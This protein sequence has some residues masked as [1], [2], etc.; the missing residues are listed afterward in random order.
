MTR[1]E[2]NKVSVPALPSEVAELLSDLNNLKKIMPLDRIS[3][4]ISDDKSCSFKIQNLA[5][6][7]LN[8]KSTSDTL[9]EMESSS[10][11]PFPFNLSVH[12]TP[13]D[14]SVDAQLIF[15]GNM[16]PMLKMMAAKPLTNFFNMLADNLVKLYK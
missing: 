15:E 10:D 16:N 8:L 13:Q 7:G 12:L 2:S 1:L 6:I 5:K 3:D 4:W 9:I 11:K 14:D